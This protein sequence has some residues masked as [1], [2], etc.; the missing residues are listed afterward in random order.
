MAYRLTYAGKSLFDP[1][2]DDTVSEAKLTNSLNNPSYLDFDMAPDHAL[3]GEVAER[4]GLVELF[5]DGEELFAGQ[6][7][8]V[9]VDTQGTKT[10]SCEGVMAWLGDT[11]VRPYSTVEGEQGLTAPSSVDGLF[12]WYVDQHNAHTMDTNK[13]FSVGINQGAC[14]DANNYV[15]RSSSQLPATL[16]EIK[17][18][19]TGSMGGY[20]YAR[21]EDG[22]NWLDLYAD[23]HDMNAQVVDFGVNITDFAKA[24]DS[25]DQYTAVRPSGGTPKS[26]GESSDEG[27]GPITIE[28]LPD[29][30]TE[31]DPDVVKK[32]DVVF[33]ASAVARYGYREEAWSNTDCATEEGLLRSAVTHLRKI[34]E[35]KLTVTVKAVDL[36]LFMGGYDHLRV[37]QAVRVRSAPHGVDEYLTVNS[38]ALDLQD[39]GQSEYVL[40][41]A[42]DTLTGK[43]SGYIKSLNSG[44]NKSLDA[45]GALDQATKNAAT[46]AENAQKLAAEADKKAQGAQESADNAKTSADNA[47]SKADS[48]DKKADGAQASADNA[49]E[50][51]DAAKTD[52]SEANSN[53]TDAQERVGAI[54]TLVRTSGSGVEVAKKVDGSYTSTKTLVDDT[55]FSVLDKDGSLLSKFSSDRVELAKQSDIGEISLLKDQM[56]I[57]TEESEGEKYI[58]TFIQNN[59]PE[60]F[61]R[62]GIGPIDLSADKSMTYLD[63]GILGSPA[64]SLTAENRD[65]SDT[66]RVSIKG[67]ATD[68]FTMLQL[69][70]EKLSLGTGKSPEMV[71]M[72]MQY[73]QR[74]LKPHTWRF[75]ETDS[76]KTYI[77]DVTGWK[78]ATSIFNLKKAGPD[79]SDWFTLSGGN[80]TFKVSGLWRIEFQI[81]GTNNGRIGAGIFYGTFEE[82]STFIDASNAVNTT[83]AVLVKHFD[84]GKTATIKEYCD[85]GKMTK[86]LQSRLTHVDIEYLGNADLV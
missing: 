42:Y 68:S 33:S 77:P 61:T 67:Y 24:S 47:Q 64:F 28:A 66:N 9:E 54:E 69:F 13:R 27:R 19:I 14:L 65:S 71:Q 25:S 50:S 32:G 1:Y 7:A 45:V 23:V 38:I 75:A 52:A 3:Y 60:G 82:A 2:T 37:G 34:A 56:S 11:V 29:G 8:S 39:P 83:R 48:A 36:A 43:Q 46:S 4:D 84:A 53:A 78:T 62:I 80:I 81:G 85:G 16:D 79:Y 76:D 59:S 6:V 40:G 72:S 74:M 35:P 17:D 5:W 58:S 86:W 22:T 70:T 26:D 20:V 73:L 57:K 30:I 18:K 63:L 41:E 51:A 44:I 12:Q 21:R 55:G 31:Y 15:Y 10:V 49:Q